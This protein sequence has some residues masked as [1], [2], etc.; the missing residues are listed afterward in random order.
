M[1]IQFRAMTS[2]DIAG[3]LELCRA[4]GWNQTERDWRMFIRLSPTGCRAATINERLVGTVATV[5][6]EDRFSWIGMMLVDPAERGKGI[7]TR[8]MTGALEILKDMPSIRLDATPAGHGVYRKLGFVDEYRLSR[9]ETTVRSDWLL[10]GQ[11]PPRRMTIDDLTDVAAVDRQVFGAD[12]RVM[13]AWMIEGAPEYGWVVERGERITGYTFGRH[14]FNFEHIG[15]V[16]AKDQMAARQ[17]LSACLKQQRGKRFVLD[18]AHYEADWRA[19]LESIGF[20]EQRPLIR[21][22]YRGNPHAGL[23]QNQFAI[24][25]PEFG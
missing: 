10:T 23:P 6:Y 3:A 16:V 5:S 2:D 1:A 19:W 15:P 9:M 12:R 21:M 17:L 22:F 13:L 18:A 14:G 8:L 4:A 11:N 25:G 20:S 24:L 7:G